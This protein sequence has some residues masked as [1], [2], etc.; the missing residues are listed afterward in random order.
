MEYNVFV[1]YC[2]QLALSVD[3]PQALDGSTSDSGNAGLISGTVVA[4]AVLLVAIFSVASLFAFTYYRQK[5]ARR[6]PLEALSTGELHAEEHEQ[7]VHCI[8][9]SCENE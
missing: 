5:K 6:Q 1:L 2:P 3:E 7:L 9:C 4:V 8:L